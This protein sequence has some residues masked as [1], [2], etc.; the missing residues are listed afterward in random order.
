MQSASKKSRPRAR[1]MDIT[2]G[3]L[4]TG[5]NN[6]ITD[7]EGVTVGQTTIVKGDNVRTGITAIVPHG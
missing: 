5:Q 6:A 2:I 7:V 3:I 4:P 1:D